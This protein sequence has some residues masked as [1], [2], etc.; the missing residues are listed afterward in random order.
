MESIDKDTFRQII[1]DHWDEF[2]GSY[3][4]YGTEYYNEV[5]QKMLGCGKEE[6]G[7]SEY[8]CTHCGKDFRR[9]CFTCKSCFCLSCSK[10]YVDGVVVQVSRVLRSGLRYR[11]VILTIPDFLR[12]YFY[13]ARHDGS[14]FSAF[15]RCGY[16]CL[17]DVVSRAVKQDVKIG[18]IIVIQTHGRSGRYNVHLHI[19]MTSG[20]IN[21]MS[22]KW[23]EL[24]YFPYEMIHKSW[25]Y[26]LCRMLREMVPTDEMRGV[27]DELY[28]RYPNGF[29]AHVKKGKVPEQ[30]RG[31]AK[32]LAKYVASPPIAV[33]RILRYAGGLV[34]YWYKDHETRA[35]KVETVDVL[36][37]IGRMVQHI[38]P[39][40]FQRIRYY[41]L[42]ATKTFE[43]WSEVIREG[44]RRVGRVV[45]GV[46]QVVASKNYRERYEELSGRD[47]MICRYCG[48]EMELWKIFHP[49]YGVIYDEWEN[50]KAGK[51]G[52]VDEW[53][54]RGRHSVRSTTDR[55]QLSMFKLPA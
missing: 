1:I 10:G 29:V 45:R 39:K 25:Q 31:L 53:P 13:R 9:I 26:H 16:R 43:K 52:E 4:S 22:G 37:F 11:H 35:R 7:Y 55:I 23:V 12:I 46:Y 19:I 24:K 27:V 18:A 33:R 48:H 41:G 21:E 2:K 50:I 32:Y 15:M 34:T 42:Q 14:F 36:T 17:E 51:Y 47:P 40:C 6:G 44:L 8:R 20:G 54:R 5:I 28:R 49:L 3:P 30:C 38:L